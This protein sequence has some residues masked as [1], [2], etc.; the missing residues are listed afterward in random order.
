MTHTQKIELPNVRFSSWG[1]QDDALISF[2]ISFQ[3][4]LLNFE[5]FLIPHVLH[6][7]ALHWWFICLKWPPR[8]ILKCSVMFR[9]TE[10]C[11]VPYRE[12]CMCYI[13]FIQ[14]WELMYAVSS[15]LTNHWYILNKMSLHRNTHTTGWY[16]DQLMEMLWPE[17][18]RKLNLYF[19]EEKWLNSC[20][21]SFDCNFIENNY[22]E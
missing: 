11:D 8:I 17:V 14:A 20:E 19:H 6:N 22:H 21:V 7:C 12:K 13:S 18:H 9:S 4:V 3:S 1:E 5:V 16:S 2:Q 10:G 15:I